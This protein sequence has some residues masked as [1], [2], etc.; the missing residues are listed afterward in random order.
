MLSHSSKNMYILLTILL[1]ITNNFDSPKFCQPVI[2]DF[3]SFF[4]YCGTRVKPF[5][6][7]G[8]LEPPNL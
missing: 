2:I 3:T 7:G 1:I 6:W 5:A 4:A 8:F